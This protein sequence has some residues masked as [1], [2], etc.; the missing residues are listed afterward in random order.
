MTG[1][2]KADLRSE[3]AEVSH[4]GKKKLKCSQVRGGKSIVFQLQ[5]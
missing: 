3:N 1:M 2:V 4:V 5:V